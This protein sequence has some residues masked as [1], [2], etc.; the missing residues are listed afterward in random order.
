M[1]F[2]RGT[3]SRDRAVPDREWRASP[4]YNEIL[5]PCEVDEFLMSFQDLPGGRRR[6]LLGVNRLP[7]EPPFRRRERR[8]VR[9]L[10][11]EIGRHLGSALVTLGDPMPSG[12]PPRVRQALR[13]LLEGDAEKQVARRLGVS[14]STAHDYVKAIYRH[15]RVGSRAGL[16]A[17]FLRRTGFRLPEEG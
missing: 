13:G 15:F 17:H 10:H 9:L 5:R 3:C 11:A 4:H 6:N 16:L 1:L 2:T 12:L 8:L 14:T 7:G